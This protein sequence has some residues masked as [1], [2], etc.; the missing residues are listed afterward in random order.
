[1]PGPQIQLRATLSAAGVT[2]TR[3]VA[4]GCA[5]VTESVTTPPAQAIRAIETRRVGDTVALEALTQST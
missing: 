4:P 1:M 5:S 2:V 3:H